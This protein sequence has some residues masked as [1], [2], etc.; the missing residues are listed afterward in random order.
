MC[1]IRHRPGGP[2]GAPPG[3]A[4]AKRPLAERA[5][6]RHLVVVASLVLWV[7]LAWV[8]GAWAQPP[9]RI[10]FLD[11]GQGDAVLI[12]SPSGQAVLYDGGPAAETALRYLEQRG[13]DTLDLVVAS[14]IT[15]TT[16]AGWPPYCGGTA[17]AFTWTTAYPRRR[18]R[19][20]GCFRRSKRRAVNCSSRPRAGSILGTWSCT[21]SHR[22]A[23]DEQH[24]CACPHRKAARACLSR[25][26]V[27]QNGHWGI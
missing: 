6:G 7:L 14:T 25:S 22:P 12:E 17:R 1:T 27:I 4:A 21:S 11:V 20:G 5:E 15:R 13:V 19:T 8:A 16:S 10:A 24:A 18:R 23:F 26:L 9:L 3:G 2:A